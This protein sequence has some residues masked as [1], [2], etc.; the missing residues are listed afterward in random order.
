MILAT[1]ILG[2]FYH[3]FAKESLIDGQSQVSLMLTKSYANSMWPSHA[4]FVQSAASLKREELQSSDEI[5]HIHRDLRMLLR[6]V[7]ILM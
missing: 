4:G 1:I 7:S 5:R 3:L 6:G 2:Y